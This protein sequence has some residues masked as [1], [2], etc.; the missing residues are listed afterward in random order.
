MGSK[1]LLVKRLISGRRLK[2]EVIY[3]AFVSPS[4]LLSA[5]ISN[6]GRKRENAKA[7]KLI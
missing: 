2:N 3:P 1:V 6:S 4:A 7:A 5:D